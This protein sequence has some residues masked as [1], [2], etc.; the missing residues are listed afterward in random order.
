MGC[1]KFAPFRKKNKG[2]SVPDPTDPH[3]FGPPGFGSTSQGMDPNLIF[4][5]SSKNSKKNLDPYSFVTS[6]GLFIFSIIQWH[7]SADPDPQQNFIDPEH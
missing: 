5:S 7:G 2:T 1:A 3:V 4:L 6:F